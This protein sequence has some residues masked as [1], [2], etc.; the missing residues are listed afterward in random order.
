MP[1]VG[2][3]NWEEHATVI[4]AVASTVIVLMRL[5]AVAYFDPETAFA[6]LQLAGTTT[7]VIGT[8]LA[9]IWVVVAC[10]GVA[11]MRYLM[12]YE[13]NLQRR[14]AFDRALFGGSVVILLTA[15]TIAA[16]LLMAIVVIWMYVRRAYM[17]EG[18]GESKPSRAFGEFVLGVAIALTILLGAYPW[19]PLE[20]LRVETQARVHV[21]YVLRADSETIVVLDDKR[22]RIDYLDR[23]G[24][25]VSR[26]LCSRHGPI[27]AA[28]IDEP[29][30][31][32]VLTTLPQY[33]K[34]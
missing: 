28:L 2:S 22:R 21:G 17:G 30:L 14:A 1:T 18:K 23:K 11:I 8:L 29:I 7:V 33:P 5:L 27:E 25:A 9:S 3:W 6:I 31:S 16:L 4:A 15:P 24:L 12:Q 13:L 19:M 34:C 10:V 32:Y 20:R 26:E